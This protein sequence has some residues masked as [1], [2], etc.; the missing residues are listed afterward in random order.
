MASGWTC[1]GCAKTNP[2]KARF[3][4]GCGTETG[5][6]QAET[7]ARTRPE[8]RSADRASY[9]DPREH[10]THCRIHKIALDATGFCE[11][12]QSWW[13]PKFRCPECAGPLWDNGY[14]ATC[15]PQRKV[16]PGD[17]FEQRWD[18]RAGREWGHFVRVYQGPSPAPSAIEIAGYVAQLRALIPTVGRAIG[19][20]PTREP[21]DEPD[22][23]REDAA[24]V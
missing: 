8:P 24:H 10:D 1:P 13:V 9:L 11:F 5:A 3:C 20:V 19:Q 23:I 14:C 4:A 2:T 21:G 16:F 17:Y 6:R 18:A 22:W 12:G 7:T 15:T